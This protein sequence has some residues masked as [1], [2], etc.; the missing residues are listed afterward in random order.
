VSVAT[1][2]CIIDH[3]LDSMRIHADVRNRGG[4]C[5]PTTNWYEPY[6]QIV[7]IGSDCALPYT[8]ELSNHPR[9]LSG[10]SQ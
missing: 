5:T 8:I 4:L 2:G 3:E 6:E 9:R 7:D 10:G 1:V